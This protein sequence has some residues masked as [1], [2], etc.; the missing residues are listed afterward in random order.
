MAKYYPCIGVL[1]YPDCYNIHVLL[2]VRYKSRFIR[3]GVGVFSLLTETFYF[4]EKLSI[5]KVPVIFNI[6][7]TQD[8]AANGYFYCNSG[9]GKLILIEKL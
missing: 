7:D 4:H 9:N 6:L 2:F 5:W 3:I 1:D 8:W